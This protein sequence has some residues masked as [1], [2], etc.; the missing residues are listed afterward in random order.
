MAN[1][2]VAYTTNSGSTA[3]VAEAIAETLRAGQ[4]TVE[5]RRLEEVT[6]LAAYQA[7]VIGAPMILGWHRA[8]LNF[9]K[10]QRKSL[11]G[12]K[13]AVFCTA[14]SLT[15]GDGCGPIP[16]VVWVD[17]EL[18]KEPQQPGKLGFKERFTTTAHYVAPILKGAEAARPVS[19]AFFGGK[20]ELFR[21]KWWQVLFVMV[22][23]EAQP[24][25]RRNWPAIRAWAG[26]LRTAL[27]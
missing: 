17:P 6:D 20:L 12:K 7:V 8:A 4:D 22:V 1:L 11:A 19:I 15:Q 18:P 25:D 23:V 24:G 16:E 2:L 9:I 21:L 10:K 3:E 14:M 13:V 5:V 26:E 27:L